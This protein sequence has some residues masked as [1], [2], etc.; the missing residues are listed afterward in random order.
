MAEDMEVLEARSDALLASRS[1]I[2]CC[3][4]HECHP[5]ATNEASSSAL[6]T[7]S[8]RPASFAPI[9]RSTAAIPAAASLSLSLS[10]SCAVERRR[11][12]RVEKTGTRLPS[13]GSGR[14]G[15]NHWAVVAGV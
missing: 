12:A 5:S 13:T 2:L 8:S 14:S 3:C 9:P 4:S 6:V 7:F 1:S 11:P 10:L 15:P